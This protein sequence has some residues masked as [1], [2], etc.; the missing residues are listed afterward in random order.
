MYDNKN[1]KR[2]QYIGSPSLT[3]KKKFLTSPIYLSNVRAPN[4]NTVFVLS[5]LCWSS[6]LRLLQLGIL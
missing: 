3:T 4:L 5:S 2:W 1:H 6:H